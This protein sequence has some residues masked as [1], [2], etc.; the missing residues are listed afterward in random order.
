MSRGRNEQDAEALKR[1]AYDE[2]E[3]HKR[4]DLHCKRD[5][6]K[7]PIEGDGEVTESSPSSTCWKRLTSSKYSAD[8]LNPIVDAVRHSNVEWI[9]VR[10]EEGAALGYVARGLYKTFCA[11]A[12]KNRCTIKHL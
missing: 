7:E 1:D 11:I 2:A 6:L 8:S 5:H 4:R 10:H 3:N 9:G 12:V